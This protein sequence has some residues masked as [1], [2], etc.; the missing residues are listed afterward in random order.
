VGIAHLDFFIIHTTTI[1]LE[2]IPVLSHYYVTS[3]FD[4]FLFKYKARIVIRDDLQK[5][6]NAQNVYVATFALKIFR[7][8][9]TL[10]AD[11]HLK[12]RQLNA[13][14]IFLNVFNDEKMY[15]H[16]SNEYKQLKK[17]LKLF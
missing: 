14:N 17:I 2:I 5:V 6:N 9:I 3:D 7:M 15:C 10:V 4:E 13:V 1:D 12:I 8:M 16:M 11:F